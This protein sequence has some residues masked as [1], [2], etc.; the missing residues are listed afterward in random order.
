MPSWYLLNIVN[1]SGVQYAMC[2]CMNATCAPTMNAL[3]IGNNSHNSK[4]V[5]IEHCI[6]HGFRF[7]FNMFYHARLMLVAAEAAA[8]AAEVGSFL[9]IY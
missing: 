5:C 6:A 4:C 8:A 7:Q 3:G 2:M 1:A 9:S